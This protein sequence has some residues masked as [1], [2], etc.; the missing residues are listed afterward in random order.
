MIEEFVTLQL[1]YLCWYMSWTKDT[2]SIEKECKDN[3]IEKDNISNNAGGEKSRTIFL[4]KCLQ[5]NL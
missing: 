4:Y 2:E 3:M 1:D 5:E